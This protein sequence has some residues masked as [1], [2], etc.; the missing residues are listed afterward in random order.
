MTGTVRR[1]TASW[2]EPIGRIGLATQGALYA[3]VAVIAL[4]VASGHSDDRADQRGAIEAVSSQSFGRLL[5]TALTIGLAF[6]CV[7]RLML[8]ARGAVGDDDATEWL[9]R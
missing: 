4:Q 1:E 3:V 9:K 2:V 7:W 8:A 5:L 6:H